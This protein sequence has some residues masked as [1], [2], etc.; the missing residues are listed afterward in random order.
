MKPPAGSVQIGANMA[1]R[2]VATMLGA[3]VVAATALADEP[4]RSVLLVPFGQLIEIVLTP[5]DGSAIEV[6]VAIDAAA[7]VKLKA[8]SSARTIRMRIRTPAGVWYSE[9]SP[10][11]AGMTF[12]RRDWPEQVAGG[13]ARSGGLLSDFLRSQGTGIPGTTECLVKLVDPDP[14]M[15]TI[16][17]SGGPLVEGGELVPLFV[18]FDKG[19]VFAGG[20]VDDPH[21][22]G[23]DV[24][25]G[26]V[27]LVG[28]NRLGGQSVVAHVIL[29]DKSRHSV[30]LRDDGEGDPARASPGLYSGKLGGALVTMPGE[31]TVRFVGSGETLAG[32]P[33]KRTHAAGFRV[34]AAGA[35]FQPGLPNNAS[36]IQLALRPGTREVDKVHV[37]TRVDV[38]IPG[39]YRVEYDLVDA[40]GKELTVGRGAELPVGAHDLL[41]S[42]DA[43]DAHGLDL[44]GVI[45]LVAARLFRHDAEQ[46]QEVEIGAMPASALPASASI[47]S[48]RA[49]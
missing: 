8:V 42:V 10:P 34:S 29:P 16:E 15:Y 17:L 47:T 12:S 5:A 43:S 41:V 49:R 19:V 18:D 38:Q 33:F 39:M 9:D 20:V 30:V 45:Q 28:R 40:A 23:R 3:I 26:G 14:G 44:R 35:S 27:L 6:P 22:V 46:G 31:Y 7:T 11:E 25:L 48:T 1:A 2:F 4:R 36:M 32:H 13:G 21:V 24:Q 37:R